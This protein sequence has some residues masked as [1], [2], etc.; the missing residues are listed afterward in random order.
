[1]TKLRFLKVLSLPRP[2]PRPWSRPLRRSPSR[3]PPGDHRGSPPAATRAPQRDGR[4]RHRRAGEP[5]VPHGHRGFLRPQSPGP[6]AGAVLRNDFHHAGLQGLDP[7]DHPRCG[8]R[9]LGHRTRTCGAATRPTASSRAR[10]PT[11]AAE[12]SAPTHV[13]LARQGRVEPASVEDLPRPAKDSAQVDARLRQ[14]SAPHAHRR[15]R[16]LRNED[17]LRPQAGPRL[18][19][20]LLLADGRVQRPACLPGKGISMLPTFEPSGHIWYTR[21]TDSG[22]FIT[23][24]GMQTARRQRQRRQHGPRSLQRSHVLHVVHGDGNSE[25]Y[26]TRLDGTDVKRVTNHPAIDTSPA[27][28]PDNRLAFVSARHGTPQIF[29]MGQDGSQPDPRHLPRH[30]QPNARVVQN[31]VNKNLSPSLVATAPSTSSPWTSAPRST[32]ASPKARA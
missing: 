23:R 9:R 25:I 22:M 24:S 18:K 4:H 26:S 6:E 2:W 15:P 20:R 28:G 32:R 7:A 5:G 16:P 13:L 12:T 27:C 1:M 21:L 31:G 10:S 8:R 30:P 3:R 29:V 17:H 11:R 14:R 19:G